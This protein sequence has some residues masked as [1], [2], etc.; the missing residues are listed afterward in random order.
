MGCLRSLCQTIWWL[1]L[2]IFEETSSSGP[3]LLL[4]NRHICRPRWWTSR[5]RCIVLILEVQLLKLLNWYALLATKLLSCF[6]VWNLWHL[7]L[8]YYSLLLISSFTCN[9][10]VK[11]Y[12]LRG[13]YFIYSIIQFLNVWNC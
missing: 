10:I 5:L 2:S 12:V 6:T 8:E 9:L 13:F 7:P 11:S 4:L 3:F 1:L